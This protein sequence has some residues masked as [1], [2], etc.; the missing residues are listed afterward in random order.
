VSAI[1]I[2]YVLGTTAGGTGRHV[3]MLAA[4]CSG[5]GLTVAAFGPAG[6]RQV[7]APGSSSFVPV[8]IADRPRPGRDAAVILRLRRLLASFRPDVVHAHGL[9][10]G[11][12]TALALTPA[13][14]HGPALLV[15]VHNARPAGAAAGTVYQALERIVARRAD[16]VLAVSADLAGRMQRRGARDVG[17][18][19]VPAPH[20]APP[21]AA[22]IGKALADIGANGAPL[23]LAAGRLAEQKGLAGLLDAAA[24]WQ[25]RD[26]RPLLVIAGS[27]PL[28]GQLAGQARAQR[29]AAR[30]LGQR[31]DVPALLAAADVVVVPSHWEGQPLIVQE[32]L[33]AGRPL[34]AS[35]V[36]GIP[37]LTGEDAALLVPP[38]DS[39][40]LA[41]AVLA[42]LG[43]PAL[44]RRLGAAAL[45][46]AGALAS[47]SAAVDAAIA[48]YQRLANRRGLPE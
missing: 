42:V 46:R 24:G 48:V 13:P 18:A 44:A 8:E 17:L 35:R 25:D 16:A 1:R 39:G 31:D 22:E 27:G 37:E 32:A 4:G 21:S 47:E 7:L 38:R 20:P 40:G 45:A 36:G 14:R 11:A 43:D 2:A 29:L 19:V 6:I 3:G 15:T 33:R 30:F 26:P 10:A 12:V 9:R 34:V 23:V 41:A 28:A 5:R